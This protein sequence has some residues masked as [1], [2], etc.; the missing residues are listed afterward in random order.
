MSVLCNPKVTKPF[1]TSQQT[2]SFDQIATQPKHEYRNRPSVSFDETSISNRKDEHSAINEKKKGLSAHNN[3]Q[4]RG[5][6]IRKTEP[7]LKSKNK[8]PGE[9]K[10]KYK[11]S[12][13]LGQ[14]RVL[15]VSFGKTP[16]DR[17]KEFMLEEIPG[18]CKF[19]SRIQILGSQNELGPRRECDKGLCIP[20]NKLKY[21]ADS[22]CRCNV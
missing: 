4:T 13:I 19:D 8:V 12:S 7:K 9:E 3:I 6:C 21:V 2:V 1:V 11:T 16:K 10:K 22:E 14:K 15:P 20:V 5:V 17:S 18:R